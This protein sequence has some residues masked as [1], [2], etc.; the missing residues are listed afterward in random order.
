LGPTFTKKELRTSYFVAAKQSHPDHFRSEI[1]TATTATPSCCTNER[2][3]DA[4]EQFRLV[5]E[6]YELL[7]QWLQLR[8]DANAKQVRG[9]NDDDYDDDI[10]RSSKQEELY[11]QA[12]REWLGQ[13]AEIVEESKACPVFRQWLRGGRTDAAQHWQ[14]FFMLHGGLAPRLKQRPKLVVLPSSADGHQIENPEPTRRRR[15]GR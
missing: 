1:S 11:R 4:G 3:L 2:N 6:A 13:S 9:L 5:T 12:C 14:S 8:D 7:S 10:S 15:P